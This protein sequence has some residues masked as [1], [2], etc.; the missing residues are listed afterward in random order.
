M[1]LKQF[2]EDVTWMRIVEG[3]VRSSTLDHVY[4]NDSNLINQVKTFSVSSG[5]H[6][7]VMTFMNTNYN[8]THKKMKIRSWKNNT[9]EGL[10][11]LLRNEYWNVKWLSVQDYCDELE[12]KIMTVLEE[13]IPF[14]EIKIRRNVFME[15]ANLMEMKKKRKN[16]F[17][18]A[19]RRNSEHLLMKCKL[20]DKKIRLMENRDRRGKVR[21]KM[22]PGDQRSLWEAVK[23]AQ[24]KEDTSLP[25]VINLADKS[26]KTNSGKAGQT[27]AK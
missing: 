27:F 26:A 11:L 19:Q 13:I 24:S 23:L 12:Q 5:D 20:M 22:K 21:A 16:M 3:R 17:C 6:M 10:D 25:L 8:F 7:P 4:T 1:N 2:V 9:K 18:N 15:S 14:K